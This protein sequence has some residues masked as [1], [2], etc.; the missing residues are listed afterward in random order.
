[1]GYLILLVCYCCKCFECAGLLFLMLLLLM[2]VVHKER[3]RF[4]RSLF[5]CI[6]VHDV[7]IVNGSFVVLLLL[8]VCGYSCL[9]AC[10]CVFDGCFMVLLLSCFFVLVLWY[11]AHCGVSVVLPC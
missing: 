11:I 10:D 6:R 7:I 4:V 8:C 5:I 1:M 2:L 9:I 3:V